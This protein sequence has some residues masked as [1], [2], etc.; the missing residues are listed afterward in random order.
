MYERYYGAKYNGKL[1]TKEVAQKFREDV[2]AAKAT[3]EL[4]KE[5]KLSVRYESFSG[6][7]AINVEV[8]AVPFRVMNPERVVLEAQK[9]R[10]FHETY[11]NPAHTEEAQVLEKR[12]ESML[13]AYNH[14]GSE[15]QFDY[16]DV[17]FY[18]HVSWSWEL[19][20]AEREEILAEHAA[21]QE[22]QKE[23]A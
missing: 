19:E 2:K 20:K 21:N 15:S 4:P 17:K 3:G 11:H 18:G 23:A 10:E 14:D 8:K 6:G 12:L 7:S 16:F 13:Q 22:S 5:L 1:S 9:P